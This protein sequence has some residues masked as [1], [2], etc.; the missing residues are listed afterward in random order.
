MKPLFLL[1]ALAFITHT[2]VHAQP[3]ISSFTPVSGPVGAQVTIA[4]NNFGPFTTDNIVYFGAVRATVLTASPTSLKV[5]VP[6][7]ATFQPISVTVNDRVA[8]TARPFIITYAG[9]G[10]DFTSTSFQPAVNLTGGGSIA[11]CDLDKDGRIDLISTV[12]ASDQLNILRNTTQDKV[13]SF[14]AA[15]TVGNVVNP[16]SV[17]AADIDGDGLPDLIVTNPTLSVVYVIKNLST[18][19]NLDFD[20]SQS[21]ATGAGCRK[22]ATGD[23]DGDG[24]TDIVVANT[25]ASTVSVLRNTSSGGAITFSPKVDFATTSDPEGVA[26]GDLDGDGKPEIAVA[27]YQAAGL[28]SVLKNTSVAG[29]ISFNSKIDY[30]TGTWPWDVS[31]VDLDGDGKTD[32]I[33]SNNSPNTVSVFRNTTAGVLDFAQRVDLPLSSSSPRGM[34][35][36]DLNADGKPD[37]VTANWFVDSKA[38]VLKN[39]STPGTI[40]FTTS[41]DYTANT[42]AGSVALADLNADG[43]TD[44]VTANSNSSSL[45]YFQNQLGITTFPDC[46]VLLQ[47]ANNAA[48]VQYDAPLLFT[49]HKAAGASGYQIEIKEQSGATTLDNTTDTFYLFYMPSSGINYTWKVTPLNIPANT[50]TCPGFAFS[51]CAPVANPVTITAEGSTDRCMTDSVLLRASDGANVQWFLDAQPIAG[52]TADSFWAKNAGNYSLRVLNGACYSDMSNTIIV[53]PLWTP[54]KPSITPDRDTLLCTGGSVQFTTTLEISNQWFNGNTPI[55]G[56]NGLSYTATAAGNYYLRVTNSTSGCH[57]YSDTVI[58][59]IIPPLATPVIT[60]NGNTT[61]CAGENTVLQSSAAAGNQWFRNGTAIIGEVG[62]QYTATQTGSYTV[63]VTENTCTSAIS[64]EVAITVNAVPPAPVINPAGGGSF[65]SGD[66]IKLQSS[67]L[68][69]NQWLKNGAAI[70]DA[71]GQDYCAKEAASYAVKTT[72]SGCTSDA[73][74]AATTTVLPLPVKPVVT[75]SSNTMSVGTGYASYQWYFNNTLIA[76]AT[77]NQYTTTQSG[78]YKVVVKD[79]N[80]CSNTSDNFNFVTTAVNDVVLQGSLVQWYPNPVQR[81]LLIKITAGTGLSARVTLRIVD[82]LGRQIHQEQL[83]KN[84]LNTIPL[85]QLPAGTYW[86]LLRSGQSEKAVKVLKVD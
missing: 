26:V 40:S 78:A 5:T 2:T 73:S 77:T 1:L 20:S 79:N 74:A 55:A 38:A 84:G 30:I 6:V 75:A 56:A 16:I 80:N 42:G 50:V 60:T 34:A 31:I 52:A 18:S 7:G 37:I 82:L 61:I 45:S 68:S 81:N 86:I 44:I 13:I 14:A 71:T 35:L 29:N 11:A 72:Q 10:M 49:W 85:Q 67:A 62:Q 70:A 43:L 47:P 9:G 25:S 27:G 23:I 33:S 24:K 76:G 28:L 22:L 39:N 65:C 66:S 57:N 51:T 41:T 21:F 17:Q 63:Q 48:N 64:T 8:Y 83:L 54:V 69:G 4:G 12:F 3:V 58:V 46:P 59:G 32:L 53:T 36:N 19:G 15:T